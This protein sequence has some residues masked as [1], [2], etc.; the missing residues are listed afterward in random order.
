MS[1]RTEQALQPAPRLKN[2][3]L[4]ARSEFRCLHLLVGVG[5]DYRDDALD[6]FLAVLLTNQ[7]VDIVRESN[8]LV[9]LG[10]TRLVLG[11]SAGPTPS[12]TMNS[13]SSLIFDRLD[14]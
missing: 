2:L 14:E 5:V 12:T 11:K 4:A 6:L 1:T 13:W 8:G 7:I 9:L 10:G 3:L